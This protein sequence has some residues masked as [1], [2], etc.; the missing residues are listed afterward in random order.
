M[1]V[2]AVAVRSPDL[3]ND[4]LESDVDLAHPHRVSAVIGMKF[5]G[6][7][8][9]SGTDL[10]ERRIAADTKHGKRIGGHEV[11]GWVAERSSA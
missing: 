2:P 9:S 7:L 6:K 11:E 4:G 5:G 3:G 1:R 10:V 8:A